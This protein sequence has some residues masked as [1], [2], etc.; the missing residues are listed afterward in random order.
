MRRPRDSSK[1]AEDVV[2]PQEAH[3]FATPRQE[4]SARFQALLSAHFDRTGRVDE[5]RW[6]VYHVYVRRVSAPRP[7]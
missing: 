7:S 2:E 1:D 4:Q 6:S 3:Y 5:Y